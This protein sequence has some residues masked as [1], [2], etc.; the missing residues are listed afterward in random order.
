[1]AGHGNNYRHT[2]KGGGVSLSV[3]KSIC[4]QERIDL[5]TLNDTTET[6]FI[7]IEKANF[8]TPKNVLIGVIYRPPAS[9]INSFSQQFAEILH[10]LDKEN[11]LVYLMGDFNINLFNS[12]KYIPCSDFLNLMYAHSYI[13][14]ITKATRVTKSSATLIDNI[15]TN[16]IGS[17][18]MNDILV[19]DISDHFPIYTI[20]KHVTQKSKPQ[21]KVI[22]VF[23][24]TNIRKFKEKLQNTDWVPVLTTRDP[25]CGYDLFQKILQSTYDEIF[26]E[27]EIRLNYKN[28]LHWLSPALLLINSIKIKNKLYMIYKKRPIP[29]NENKYKRYKHILNKATKVAE[30]DYYEDIFR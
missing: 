20:T 11:K 4:F 26:P 27:K 13:P 18:N 1:M 2:K 19:T 7:E 28:R 25:Q 9:D 15:F 8:G 14:L 5:M 12:D 23:S 21:T 3:H 6:V 22:R 16:N 10:K 24:E 30:Q 29:E 17:D